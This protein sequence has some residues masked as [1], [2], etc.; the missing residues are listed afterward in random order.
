MKLPVGTAWSRP[1]DSTCTLSSHSRD[2]ISNCRYRETVPRSLPSSCKRRLS[3]KCC[4]SS[5]KCWARPRV[6]PCCV[7]NRSDY[8]R[9]VSSLQSG[10]MQPA[11]SPWGCSEVEIRQCRCVCER[12]LWGSSGREI[13]PTFCDVITSLRR[14]YSVLLLPDRF[15]IGNQ[16][17]C[18]SIENNYS[19][20]KKLKFPSVYP[21]HLRSCTVIFISFFF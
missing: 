15:S 3:C 11:V 1:T 16:D 14:L 2:A 21:V 17:G 5:S 6:D 13:C 12:S 19:R 10:K 4:V 20:S 7:C 9:T 18:K 8:R